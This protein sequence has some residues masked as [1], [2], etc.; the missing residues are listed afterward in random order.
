MLWGAI[1]LALL[2]AGRA[3]TGD[4]RRRCRIGAATFGVFAATDVV[5]IFIGSWGRP[6]ALFVVKAACVG[7]MVWLLWADTVDRRRTATTEGENRESEPAEHEGGSADR[8]D[9]AE[10]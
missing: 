3:Q 2:L 9:G 5:E 4:R 10:N 1:A 8:S 6:L 7:T